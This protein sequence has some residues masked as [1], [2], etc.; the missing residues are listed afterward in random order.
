VL[1]NEKTTKIVWLD[2]LPTPGWSLVPHILRIPGHAILF[3]SRRS[4]VKFKMIPNKMTTKI[5][6]LNRYLLLGEVW[7]Y[8]LMTPATLFTMCTWPC[9]PAVTVS[10]QDYGHFCINISWL[11][12]SLDFSFKTVVLHCFV[13]SC[14]YVH[15]DHDCIY[16]SNKTHQSQDCSS[17]TAVLL[18]FVC[19]CIDAHQDHDCI[20]MS[21][22]TIKIKTVAPYH[23]ATINH[24]GEKIY[25]FFSLD[26]GLDGT[27]NWT[28][29][30]SI[31]VRSD[32]L[33]IVS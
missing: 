6:W 33:L 11:P 31:A 29:W 25:W 15:Q 10:W 28:L 3:S 8:I 14:I 22:K 18:C 26:D 20:D 30:N 12:Q 19:S 16:M 27:A 23:H 1:F 32:Q 2:A 5:V 7:Y 13:C 24:D 17:K 9:T 21:N 4:W